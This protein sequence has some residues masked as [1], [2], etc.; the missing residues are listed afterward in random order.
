MLKFMYL[1]IILIGISLSS[2]VH[3]KKSIEIATEPAWEPYWGKDLL[4]GGFMVDI[5]RQAFKRV[6]Y[7]MNMNWM[8]WKR[9]EKLSYTGKY[10]GLLGCYFTEERT[11]KL[12]YSGPVAAAEVV[13]FELQGR[14]IKYA[15]LTDLVPYTIGVGRGYANT[16]EFDAADYLKKEEATDT[17]TNIRK[18]LKGRIDL[19]I[20][21]KKVVQNILNINFPKEKDAVSVVEP[22]L[23][24]RDLHI[25]ISK[26]NPN[27]KEIVKAFNRG[28]KLLKEDGTYDKILKQHGF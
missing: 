19:M 15:K 17:R 21:S 4:N 12:E 7:D 9:A 11:K 20:D 23:Q 25:G 3:A 6:G 2:Q 18:L 14:N 16:E 28:L 27:H 8:P 10:D 26:A 1:I 22:V 13:L 24:S 5:A